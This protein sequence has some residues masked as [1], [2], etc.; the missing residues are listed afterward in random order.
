MFE[1]KIEHL[2]NR[3]IIHTNIHPHTRIHIFTSLNFHSSFIDIE[4]IHLY[5]FIKQLRFI[6]VRKLYSTL[7]LCFIFDFIRRHYGFY[8][9][10]S[11]CNLEFD[12]IAGITINRFKNDQSVKIYKVN[13]FRSNNAVKTAHNH[14]A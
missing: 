10:F 14:F 6:I 2:F 9:L 8:S 12:V 3:Q 1:Q 7:F 11:N 13:S 5:T 4:L